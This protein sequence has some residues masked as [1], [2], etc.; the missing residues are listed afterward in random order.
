MNDVEP[1]LREMFARREPDVAGP[2]FAPTRAPKGLLRR[3]RIR[4]AATGLVTV[5][6]SLALLGAVAMGVRAFLAGDAMIPAA[7]TGST[8]NGITITHPEGWH[9][10]DPANLGIL[11]PRPQGLPRLV[12]VLTPTE[13]TA[14]AFGCPGLRGR[15][16]PAFLMTI[17]EMP[18]ALE[19]EGSIPWPVRLR[20]MD[21]GGSE[22]GCYPGWEFY[23]AA[24]TAE[25]RTFEA[26]VGVGPDASDADR[27]HLFD[28]FASMTFA[29]AGRGP[30]SVVLA[31]GTAA[32]EPWELIASR[33]QDG[34][35]LML[36]WADG[37]SGM[38]GFTVPAEGDVEAA[39]QTFGS[40]DD[41]EIVVFG[42]VSRRVARVE[43][44][45]ALGSPAV[46]TGTLDVPDS[47]DPERDAFVLVADADPPVELNVYDAAGD[48]VDTT[49]VA[50]GP[51]G[52]VSTPTPP[53]LP[54]PVEPAHGSMYWGAYVW[55][56]GSRRI[57][58]GGT[59]RR[60]PAGDRR[61]TVHRRS[62]VRPGSR[63]GAGED[64][65]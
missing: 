55:V 34:L 12:L 11:G 33:Q 46:S 23:R 8:V 22:S 53:E 5:F 43:A 60:G 64:A 30:G 62:G 32:G 49:I 18:L 63:R 57:G 29:P 26:R 24:W 2:A 16:A 17:Q 15:S 41:A 3:A 47:I 6:G 38:G 50:L 54:T 52:P 35:S 10:A 65:E 37:A 9:V 61:R 7:T 31:T 19:G 59:G 44:F 58:G 14:E 42:A 40:G 51:E 27:R 45:P 39:S 1:K 13:P 48:V 20:E 21:V 56:G 25:G 28:A 4:Q 36:Q